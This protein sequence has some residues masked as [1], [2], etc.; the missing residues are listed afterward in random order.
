MSTVRGAEDY[1]TDGESGFL[2]DCMDIDG[3]ADGI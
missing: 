1:L 2:R 3:F